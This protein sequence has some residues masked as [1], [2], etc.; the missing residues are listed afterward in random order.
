MA[1]AWLAYDAGQW[2]EAEASFRA[3]AEGM[4]SHTLHG[5]AAW[6]LV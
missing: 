1:D 6:D 3:V 4:P 5:E 2:T